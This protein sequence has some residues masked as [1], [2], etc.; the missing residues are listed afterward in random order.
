MNIYQNVLYSFPYTIRFLQYLPTTL[1]SFNTIVKPLVTHGKILK[2]VDF[3][4]S[5]IVRLFHIQHLS[6]LNLDFV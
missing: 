5:H 4:F 3:Q 6:Y 1:N 2:S